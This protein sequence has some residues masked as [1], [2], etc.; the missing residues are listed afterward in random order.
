MNI[1][2]PFPLCPIKGGPEKCRRLSAKVG[3]WRNPWSD[4][5]ARFLSAWRE[6]SEERTELIFLAGKKER[7]FED[8]D[9]SLDGD[10]P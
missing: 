9:L 3:G 10:V 1:K 4:E 8:T 5:R 6:E 7:G 2:S